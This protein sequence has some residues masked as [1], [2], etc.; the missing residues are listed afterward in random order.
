[1][2]QLAVTLGAVATLLVGCATPAAPSP[3]GPGA[4][5]SVEHFVAALAGAKG[6]VRRAGAFDSTPLQGQASLLCVGNEEVRVY[7]F[8]S[9]QERASVASRI[10]PK[11]PTHIG[12]SIVEWSGNPRFW[13]ADRIMVLY[14]G[15][16]PATE[17]RLTAVLG[18]PFARGVG[19]GLG[20]PRLSA[21]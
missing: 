20:G 9:D 13:Q 14:L 8:S 17:T 6:D 5:T 19:G 2:N 7:A 12:T 4:G 11:D 21:C 1:M 16:D 3:T 15:E 18:Q 10:D